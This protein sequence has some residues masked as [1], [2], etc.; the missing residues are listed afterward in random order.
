M[1]AVRDPHVPG[2]YGFCPVHALTGG[3]CPFCGALRATHDLLRGD[4]AGAWSMNPLWVLG[5]PALAAAWLR[6]TLRGGDPAANRPGR[7]W[8]AWSV[9]GVVMA[10][11]VLRNVPALAPW[12]AP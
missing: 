2:S 1:V 8:P 7:A 12:L 4:L 6:W 9:V 3:W 5:L 10:F 11:G